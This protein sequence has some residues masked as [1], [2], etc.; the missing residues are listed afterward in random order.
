[1]WIM[2]FFMLDDLGNV[3]KVS[4]LPGLYTSEASCLNA[5]S[6][7]MI[8]KDINSSIEFDCIVVD[9]GNYAD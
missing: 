9:R 7:L 6:K 8:N 5:T 4:A 1:M 2:V 3:T